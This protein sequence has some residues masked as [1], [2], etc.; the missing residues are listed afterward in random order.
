MTFIERY[1][2]SLS[3]VVKFIIFPINSVQQPTVREYTRD[4]QQVKVVE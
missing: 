2:Q 3:V 4:M 1:L